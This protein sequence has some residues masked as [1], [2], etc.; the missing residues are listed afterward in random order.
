MD[1]VFKHHLMEEVG[2][3]ERFIKDQKFLAFLLGEIMDNLFTKA[4]LQITP[5]MVEEY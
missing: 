2:L 4:D 5:L 1:K 3:L